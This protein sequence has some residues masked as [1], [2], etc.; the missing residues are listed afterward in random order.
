MRLFAR[1]LVC[2]TLALVCAAVFGQSAPTAQRVDFNKDVL[3][4]MG[5]DQRFGA[6]VPGDAVF[7]DEHGR[8]IQFGDLYGKRPLIVMPM[9]FNCPG[10]CGVE[11]D[12]LMQAAIQM[13]DLTVGRDYDVV[14]LSI[15]PKETPALTYSR[16]KPTVDLYGR[17]GSDEGFHFLTGTYDNIRKITDALGFKYVYNAKD[18][19]INHPAGLMV[20]SPKGVITGYMVNKDFP[21]AFLVHMIED[22]KASMVS[23]KT[24]TVLF[25]CIVMDPATGRRS[26]V[27]ENV[28]RLCCAAFAIGLFCWIAS[29]S[30]SGRQKHP[31]GGLPQ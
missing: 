21:A 23:P 31:K 2:S 20:L 22:A 9:Y 24:D 26:L 1:L 5:V 25:G 15:N 29:M 3:A 7:R 17:P 18:G 12:S 11:T 4:R 10:I 28:I 30:L 13:N 6:Q 16:W 27:I 19:T 14:L 8:I